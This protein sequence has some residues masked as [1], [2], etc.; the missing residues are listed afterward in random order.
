MPGGTWVAYSFD[1]P[2]QI[3]CLGICHS[4]ENHQSVLTIDLQYN[5][6]GVG[7]WTTLESMPFRSM[8]LPPGPP[9]PPAQSGVHQSHVGADCT[10]DDPCQPG[11]F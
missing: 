11:W 3:Q 10:A 7:D 4:E 5:P 2:V 1:S 6:S 8:Q 9:P